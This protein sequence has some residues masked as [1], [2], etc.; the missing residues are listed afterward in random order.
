MNL[1]EKLIRLAHDHPEFRDDLLPVIKLATTPPD[2]LVTQ[3]GDQG[4]IFQA[5]K[6]LNPPVATAELHKQGEVLWK[7]FDRFML[8]LK[9][10]GLKGGGVSERPF[11]YPLGR[12][13]VV[14]S[15]LPLTWSRPVAFTRGY[16]PAIESAANRVGWKRV[17]FIGYD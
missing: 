9:G 16:R 15:R 11:V 10:E 7:Q 14:E 4:A 2:L 17:E 6:L 1:R 5:A 8:Y 3:R 13:L 12:L